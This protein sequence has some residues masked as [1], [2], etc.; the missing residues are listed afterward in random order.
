MAMANCNYH[1]VFVFNREGLNVADLFLDERVLIL[2]NSK[3]N[4]GFIFNRNGFQ[5]YV[6]DLF[7]IELFSDEKVLNLG[8]GNGQMQ[9]LILI[10]YLIGMASGLLCLTFLYL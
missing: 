2:G 5:G 3:L 9:T 4:F 10:L 6:I 7:V 1:F 8:N